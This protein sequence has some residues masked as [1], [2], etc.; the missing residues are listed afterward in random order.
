MLSRF[1]TLCKRI[2]GFIFYPLTW[3][4]NIIHNWVA[5]N[6]IGLT[7]SVILLSITVVVLWQR[8]V[9]IIPAGFVGVIYRPLF[10]GIAMD[11]ILDE[12]VNIVFPLNTV[13]QYDA[14]MQLKKIEMEVLTKD[15]LRSDIKV[16]F[17]FQ[18]NKYGLPMLHKFVGID[19]VEKLLLPEVTGKTR[20]M[21]AELT[22]QEAFT[23]QLDNVVNEIAIMSDQ[24]ILEKLGPPGLDYVRLLRITAV[25]LE[26]MEFP[27]EIQAAIRNKIAESQIAEAGVFKVQAA[28]LE[29]ERKEV[30]AG[31]IKK[32]QDIVNVGLTD[33]YV[34]IRGIEAT[35]KLAESNNSKVV[36][37]G[38][39]PN[40]LPLILGGDSTT[41]TAPPSVAP[42]VA[43]AA[44]G[45]PKPVAPAAGGSAGSG[46]TAG[47]KTGGSTTAVGTTAGATTAG[48]TTA[49]ATTAG[50]TTAGATAAGGTTAGGTTAGGTT[51]GGTTAGGTVAGGKTAAAPGTSGSGGGSA[52]NG[53]GTEPARG[54][55]PPGPAAPNS[56]SK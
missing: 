50:A 17:Q 15:Q 21:F 28:R 5:R 30:E 41:P 19:Y 39:S 2:V 55:Q 38:S 9:I 8:V 45:G 48:A 29:A 33:N 26:S 53:A 44:G 23:K 32:Y 18:V 7:F 11:K 14:R 40:G 43:G 27:A 31:G 13:T 46:A 24:V 16:S 47:G 4:V 34:K 42:T 51:A 6:Y 12:G 3:F 37:F 35:L 20:V 49:G 25:Q 1:L 22:S 56:A 54:G 36:I 10:G 52:A